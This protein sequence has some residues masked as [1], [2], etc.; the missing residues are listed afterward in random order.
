LFFSFGKCIRGVAIGTPQITRG[1]PHE[2]A[3]QT[4]EGAF[5]LQAQIDFIDGERLGHE[6][7]LS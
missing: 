2:N 5:T 6:S 1:E 3:G 4:R 7:K